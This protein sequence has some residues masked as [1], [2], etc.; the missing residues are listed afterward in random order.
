MRKSL[1]PDITVFTLM[2]NKYEYLDICGFAR[3]ENE[4]LVSYTDISVF[5][6]R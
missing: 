1:N 3:E 6:S 2:E 4:R 5:T